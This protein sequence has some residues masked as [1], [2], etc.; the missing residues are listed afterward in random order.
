[1]CVTAFVQAY[2]AFDFTGRSSGDGLR[3]DSIRVV[4]MIDSALHNAQFL[5]ASVHGLFLKTTVTVLSF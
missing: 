1:M 3:S 4:F 2:K 5:A